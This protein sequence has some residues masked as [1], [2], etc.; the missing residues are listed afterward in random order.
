MR[1]NILVSKLN[2]VVVDPNVTINSGVV[3][4]YTAHFEF[5]QPWNSSLKLFAVFKPVNDVPVVLSL[6]ENNDCTIP[7]QIYKR[8][9]KLGVGLKGINKDESGKIFD[10]VATN[11]FYIP[12]RNSGV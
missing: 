12:I 4:G 11:L 5:E 2:T 8:F 10:N 6:D 1:I 7:P 3:N 9:A